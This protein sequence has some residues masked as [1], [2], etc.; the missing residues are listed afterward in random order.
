MCACTICAALSAQAWPNSA[1]VLRSPSAFSTMRCLAYRP[2]T[3]DTT[4]S[5]KSVRPWRCGPSTFFR[6]QR[7]AKRRLSLFVP[8]LPDKLHVATRIGRPADKRDFLPRFR[9]ARTGGG[10]NRGRRDV[11]RRDSISQMDAI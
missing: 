10:A 1:L 5:L 9:V 6:L 3:I 2:C 8:P 11:S 4:I 7:S